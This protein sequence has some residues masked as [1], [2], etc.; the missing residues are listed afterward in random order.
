MITMYRFTTIVFFILFSLLSF[1]QTQTKESK[2]LY[3]QAVELY[4]QGKYAECIPLFMQVDS[5]ENAGKDQWDHDYEWVASAYYK[6]GE[7]LNALKCNDVFAYQLPPIDRRLTTQTDSLNNLAVVCFQTQDLDGTLKFLDAARESVLKELGGASYK[8]L[9]YQ[10]DAAPVCYRLGQEQEAVDLIMDMMNLCTI[11]FGKDC[12]FQYACLSDFAAFVGKSGNQELMEHLS[13]ILQKSLTDN[14]VHSDAFMAKHNLNMGDAYVVMGQIDQSVSCAESSLA[15]IAALFGKASNEYIENL[16]FFADNYAKLGKCDVARAFVDKAEQLVLANSG[17]LGDKLGIIYIAKASVL[18]KSGKTKDAQHYLRLANSYTQNERVAQ[19]Q[20]QLAREFINVMGKF[21]K[22]GKIQSKDLRTAIALCQDLE[23]IVGRT[24]PEFSTLKIELAWLLLIA[25]DPRSLT[26]V[27]EQID[28]NLALPELEPLFIATL[29]YLKHERY[30]KARQVNSVALQRLHS[31]LETGKNHP[32]VVQSEQ[33]I[34]TS[35]DVLRLLDFSWEQSDTTRYS[36]AMIKQDLLYGKLLI[37]EQKDSLTSPDFLNRLKDFL[38]TAEHK[39]FDAVMRDSVYHRY[40]TLILERYGEDSDLYRQFLEMDQR[41]QF[42]KDNYGYA[43]AVEIS[44][45]GDIFHDSALKEYEAAYSEWKE[46]RG[47]EMYVVQRK[48]E[49]LKVP[50]IRDVRKD[51]NFK[52]AMAQCEA[53]VEYEFQKEVGFVGKYILPPLAVWCEC[54]DSLGH[55][56]NILPMLSKWTQKDCFINSSRAS[57]MSL[58]AVYQHLDPNEAKKIADALTKRCSKAELLQLAAAAQLNLLKNITEIPALEGCMPDSIVLNN[59]SGIVEDMKHHKKLAQEATVL[60]FLISR[61]RWCNY[62]ELGINDRQALLPEFLRH[63][64]TIKSNDYLCAF[65]DSYDVLNMLCSITTDLIYKNKE[66]TREANELRRKVMRSRE[67]VGTSALY[68]TTYYK[69]MSCESIKMANVSTYRLAFP[70]RDLASLESSIAYCYAFND[71]SEHYEQIIYDWNK[72]REMQHAGNHSDEILSRAVDELAKKS[73]TYLNTDSLCSLAYDIAL[74][75]KGYLLRSEQKVLK[76]IEQSGNRTVLQDYREYLKVKQQLDN[77]SISSTEAMELRHKSE[78]LIRSL[79]ASSKRFDD[80]TIGME[81]SWRDVQEQLDDDEIAIEFVNTGT[82]Y[83]ALIIKKGYSAPIM[84]YIFHLEEDIEQLGDSVYTK[85]G[86]LWS[87]WPEMVFKEHETLTPLEGVKRIYFAPTGILHHL[88]IENL[89]TFSGQR[90]CDKYELKRLSSTREII[91]RKQQKQHGTAAKAAL[92]GGVIYDLDHDDWSEL[93]Q[94]ISYVDDLVMRDVPV[95]SRGAMAELSYL[96]GTLTEVTD[97][98]NIIEND[99]VATTSFL[100]KSSTE[101]HFKT[102][103]GTE[104]GILHIATHGFF[105]KEE[106]KDNPLISN[107]GQNADRESQSLS[108]N[109]LFLAGASSIL[110]GESIPQNVED[111]ILTAREISSLDF[112]NVDLVTLSACESGLG[113]VTS[114][115]VFGLQRGFKKAGVNSILMSLWKVDDEATC[116]LMTEFYSNW[117]AHKMTK[118]DALEAAKKTVRETKGWEDPKFW[119]AFILLDALD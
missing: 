79:R 1:A 36:K 97:I 103:S 112:T 86:A 12:L 20:G 62:R 56:S 44:L 35:L 99:N 87:V 13:S 108:R 119:A 109:G 41:L 71:N 84:N 40:S 55:K 27:D 85:N 83:H 77:S 91:S 82:L 6:L 106:L 19:L 64:E 66:L 111:G 51:G 48:D 98:Q 69:S 3:A 46:K 50:D 26:F 7:E 49:K 114:D 73:A 30:V 39:T 52:E 47:D 32:A 88:A 96:P 104:T 113:D 28:I 89:L 81:F 2:E 107:N 17:K 14:D 18:Q 33:L 21:N 90:M 74:F 68:G 25:N 67:E 29:T 5:I 61:Y 78:V 94:G 92:F 80:Y 43:L 117:I 4:N 54:A 60:D 34:D 118:H 63:Y 101:E 59:L 58:L 37:M 23:T 53:V 65:E 75:S 10:Y 105:Q 15:H 57:I 93:A 102:L 31:A 45:P 24:N 110:Y 22:K 100:G 72:T 8:S 76:V 70:E 116:K 115:G 9:L 38:S 11:A 95:V 16:V 42:E